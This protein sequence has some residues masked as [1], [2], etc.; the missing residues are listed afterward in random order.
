M[1]HSPKLPISELKFSKDKFFVIIYIYIYPPFTFPNDIWRIKMRRMTDFIVNIWSF[2]RRN[3]AIVP[4]SGASGPR[5]DEDLLRCNDAS[6]SKHSFYDAASF[7]CWDEPRFIV[8][9]SRCGR[10][11]KDVEPGTRSLAKK[12]QIFI[13]HPPFH[14]PFGGVYRTRTFYGVILMGLI[15][16]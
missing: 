13:L 12:S 15:S 2:S 10:D 7:A 14:P 11:G 8:P 1:L 6:F 16:K 4:H 9:H 3:N 5:F